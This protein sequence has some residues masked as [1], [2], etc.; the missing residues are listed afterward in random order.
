MGAHT[1]L[2]PKD[3]QSHDMVIGRI[4]PT[5]AKVAKLSAHTLT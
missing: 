4:R 2:D 5:S 1:Y 3:P